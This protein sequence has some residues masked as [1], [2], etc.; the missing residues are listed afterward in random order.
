MIFAAVSVAVNVVTALTLFPRMGAPGIAVASAVAGWV[1]ATMLLGVLIR[2]GHWGRDLPLMKRIPR[3]VLSAIV[4]GAALYFAERWFAVG[5]GR[6]SPLVVKATTLLSLVAGGALLY[7]V[8]AFATG[9]ADFGMIRRNVG[10]KAAPPT[11][12][13]SPGS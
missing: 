5:L 8:T 10:R 13:Q 1:N 2:R 7:F 9:G 4:M 11:K 6:G 3:L 12:G